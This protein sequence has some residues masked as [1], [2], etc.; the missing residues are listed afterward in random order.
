[1]ETICG[2]DI[3]TD[4]KKAAEKGTKNCRA[5]EHDADVDAAMRHNRAAKRQNAAVL[6]AS[7]SRSKASS[8][9]FNY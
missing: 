7:N 1:M 2:F 6:V 3:Q 9:I 5:I 4:T 8:I